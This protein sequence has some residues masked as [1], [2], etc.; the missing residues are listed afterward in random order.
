MIMGVVV[1]S[2]LEYV[3]MIARGGTPFRCMIM[4]MSA[5]SQR[6]EKKLANNDKADDINESAR[7]SYSYIC[8]C[9][10]L[11]SINI[12]PLYLKSN[13]YLSHVYDTLDCRVPGLFMFIIVRIIQ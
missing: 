13:C 2:L 9:I 1:S 12:S 8:P 10:A 11:L 6:R 3:E 4:R 7:H 5:E